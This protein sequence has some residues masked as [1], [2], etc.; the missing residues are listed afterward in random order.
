[1]RTG[2]GP[3]EITQSLTAPIGP[4]GPANFIKLRNASRRSAVLNRDASP[5][6]EAAIMSKKRL[7]LGSSVIAKSWNGCVGGRGYP[8]QLPSRHLAL[9]HQTIRL[10]WRKVARWG[11]ADSALKASTRCALPSAR[12]AGQAR[13]Y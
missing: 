10:Y 12:L 3:C 2:G 7:A 13:E 4:A 1:M 5:G 6:P 8:G 9:V 11:R